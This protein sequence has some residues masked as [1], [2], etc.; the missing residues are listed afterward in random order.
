MRYEPRHRCKRAR[1][2]PHCPLETYQTTRWHLML[3][4]Q[5]K[6]LLGGNAFGI[7][8]CKM[9]QF[10]CSFN[11]LNMP[12]TLLS[13]VGTSSHDMTD[14]T[15]HSDLIWLP[16]F[17]WSK[18]GVTGFH[19]VDRNWKNDFCKNDLGFF[20]IAFPHF[21]NILNTVNNTCLTLLFNNTVGNFVNIVS[22][23]SKQRL[24]L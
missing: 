18:N 20:L 17:C 12:S 3:K 13:P 14:I 24:L 21:W 19:L 8:V 5:Q 11:T 15:T 1:L 6:S 2:S 16:T 4:Q 9:W 7:V 10:C 23:G 22:N